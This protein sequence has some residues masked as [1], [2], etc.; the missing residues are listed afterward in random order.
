MTCTAGLCQKDIQC[1]FTKTNRI[2]NEYNAPMLTFLFCN[3]WTTHIYW[4]IF[5]TSVVL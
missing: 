2:N 3:Y 1:S 5:A 4:Q